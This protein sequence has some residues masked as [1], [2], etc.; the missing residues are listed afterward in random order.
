MVY[1]DSLT[2]IV[3][4]VLVLLERQTLSTPFLINP[5]F[6]NNRFHVECWIISGSAVIFFVFP[7]WLTNPESFTQL[8]IRA[9]FI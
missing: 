3:Y 6:K 8:K 5:L 9:I 7:K 1:W 2:K 4:A